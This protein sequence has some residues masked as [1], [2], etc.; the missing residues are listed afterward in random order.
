MA[1]CTIDAKALPTFDADHRN[2]NALVFP[3][4]EGG[5]MSDM[6]ISAVM[7]RMHDAKTKKV[8]EAQGWIVK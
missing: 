1:G 5:V 2:P 6:T 4:P 3:A 8:F 7:K